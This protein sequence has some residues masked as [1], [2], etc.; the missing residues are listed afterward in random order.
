[1][2]TDNVSAN[3]KDA[4]DES[5]LIVRTI[6]GDNKAYEVLVR[7]YQKLVY[8]MLYRMVG[9]HETAADLTQES[10][11]RAFHGL[12]TFRHQYK[13]RPWL[14]RIATN[15]CINH[16]RRLEPCDSLE[17]TLEENPHY[18]PKAR[19]VTE[20]IVESRELRQNLDD[21]LNTFPVRHRQIFRLYYQQ[22]LSYEEIVAVTGESISGIKS[23]LFRMRE[24]LRRMLAVISENSGQLKQKGER[25]RDTSR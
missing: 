2:T 25:S 5:G 22:D 1:V 16:L 11:I 12:K 14:L 24:Q 21:A 20:S 10:F 3:D 18:E 23:L 4:S 9:E 7:R 13:F 6:S 17:A 8:N 19:N 15:T